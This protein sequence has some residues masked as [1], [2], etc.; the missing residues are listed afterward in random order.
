MNLRELQTALDKLKGKK[1]QLDAEYC[2]QNVA[3]R[4][5]MKEKVELDKCMKLLNFVS[6]MNQDKVI[7]LFEHTISAG[8][9][10]LFDGSY[11]F[12]FLQ[13]SRG[14]SSACDFEIKCSAFPGYSD[15]VMNHGKSIQDL[16]ATVFRIIL[17][18]LDKKSR[19][20]VILDEPLT[21]I[22]VARLQSTSKFLHEICTRLGIQ[23]IIVSHSVELQ[24]CADKIIKVG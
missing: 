23:L 1:E 4:L 2:E 3:L 6:K 14:N 15:I 12:R 17:V 24:E 18:K 22:Q 11:E 10:D 8:L 20:I 21:G 13:K 7:G 19:K 16:I 9:K 5:A